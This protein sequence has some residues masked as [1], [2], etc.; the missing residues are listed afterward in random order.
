[1]TFKPLEL[2]D[3]Q[4]IIKAFERGMAYSTDESAVFALMT[5][6]LTNMRVQSSSLESQLTGADA[7]TFKD[8]TSGKSADFENDNTNILDDIRHNFVPNDTEDKSLGNSFQG[9]FNSECIPCGDRINLLAELTPAKMQH[10]LEAFLEH[11]IQMM[12]N[13]L[14][15][16]TELL[17]FFHGVEQFDMCAFL[18]WIQ[19]Y[20]CIP[21]LQRILS[22]LMAL[23]SK[24]SFEIG[25]I[26]DLVLG[27]LGTLLAPFLSGFIDLLMGYVAI[28]TGPLDCVVDS[29]EEITRKLDFT[30]FMNQADQKVA[31]LQNGKFTEVPF[32]NFSVPVGQSRKS[33][34]NA[35]GASK[36]TAE[37][38]A[39]LANAKVEQSKISITESDKLNK[40]GNE[41]KT[42][43]AQYID[44][45]KQDS[46]Y[47]LS[48]EM[49]KLAGVGGEA[50]SML[51]KLGS[52]I[53]EGKDEVRKFLMTLIEEFMKL[54]GANM[55]GNVSLISSLFVKIELSR[56]VGFIIALIEVMSGQKDCDK[57]DLSN[58]QQYLPPGIG[59]STW[60][61]DEGNIHFRENKED[62]ER[63][64]LAI[65][66]AV[67]GDL[68]NT[69]E[70]TG[71]PIFDP[72]IVHIVETITKQGYFVYNC[73]LK[74]H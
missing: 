52:F 24:N 9:I 50:T 46:I 54:T 18:K 42:L 44:S 60:T 1:M 56:M 47:E 36:K 55:S 26:F 65:M 72:A 43:Q 25:S 51:R 57:K 22:V 4:N 15:Q 12:L 3:C 35:S 20:V 16:L 71:D 62:L 38:G 28:I 61:D 30:D 40:I 48:E 37:I 41:I 58:I 34:E 67:G 13:Q 45:I 10:G 7:V 23:M 68:N 59:W 29:L 32:I 74:K 17:K 70:L 2:Q 19:E 66:E 33:D 64:N 73:P 63:A 21:D 39:K 49:H 27:L 69:I 5:P 31:E 14:Q 8:G 11:Q 6:L 53:T